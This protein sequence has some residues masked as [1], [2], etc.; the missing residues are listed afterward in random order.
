MRT[1]RRRRT[2]S[3]SRTSSCRGGK[4]RPHTS[5][6][7]APAL[8]VCLGGRGG[9][10]A[11]QAGAGD[12]SR[13][14]GDLRTE[15]R[16]ESKRESGCGPGLQPLETDAGPIRGPGLVTLR[17]SVHRAGGSGQPRWVRG[18]CPPGPAALR[19][20]SEGPETRPAASGKGAACGTVKGR[21]NPAGPLSG[22][23]GGA[24]RA[25]SVL[26]SGGPG[27]ASASV[28]RRLTSRTR[29]PPPLRRAEGP[30]RAPVGDTLR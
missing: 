19:A 8:R 4:R 7:G 24:A 27:S 16:G 23:S 22:G 6:G 14:P 10:E 12:V 15:A 21:L 26:L 25:W 3:S 11:A 29:P 5:T 1:R 13:R 9:Q 2:G 17:G 20:G 18:L 28:P 30:P